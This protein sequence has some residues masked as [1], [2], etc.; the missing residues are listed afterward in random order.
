MFGLVRNRQTV[1]Q[2]RRHMLHSM[3]PGREQLGGGMGTS[4]DMKRQFGTQRIKKQEVKA[5]VRGCRVKRRG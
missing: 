4:G 5:G 1:W 2:S 3:V